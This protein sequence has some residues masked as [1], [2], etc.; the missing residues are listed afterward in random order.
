[1]PY[2]TY[3]TKV[4]EDSHLLHIGQVILVEGEHPHKLKALCHNIERLIKGLSHHCKLV[5]T[6]L[7]GGRIYNYT[8]MNT[9][10]C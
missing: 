7:S 3:D 9:L 4:R 6:D 8:K 10:L 1:M 5:G 2:K